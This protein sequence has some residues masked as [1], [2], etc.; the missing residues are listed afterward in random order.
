MEHDNHGNIIGECILPSDMPRV[1]VRPSAAR[2]V[3][4]SV[5]LVPGAT[6]LTLTLLGSTVL[7]RCLCKTPYRQFRGHV[8]SVLIESPV[9]TTEEAKL[10]G[11]ADRFS[12]NIG[13]TVL[14]QCNV[15][16]GLTSMTRCQAASFISSI[17]TITPKSDPTSLDNHFDYD[18]CNQGG[19]S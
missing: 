2:I 11:S 4:K 12:L 6:A 17:E 19:W 5:S 18:N 14:Q 15:P 16:F 10:T 13:R 9:L 7:A 8:M 1:S 3:I